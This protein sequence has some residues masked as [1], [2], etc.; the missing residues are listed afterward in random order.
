M[1]AQE[2]KGI[3]LVKF[4]QTSDFTT[5]SSLGIADEE[6][7]HE[8][9]IARM[10]ECEFSDEQM[11]NIKNNANVTYVERDIPV[12]AYEQKVPYGISQIQAHQVHEKGY[13]GSGVKL[14]ILDTGIDA[15][16]ED[17]NVADGFS[18]F[19]SG[20]DEDPYH[21]GSGHGTHVA[22]TAAAR[23]N[24]TGVVGVAPEAELYAVKVLDSNGSG[25]S[26]G[27]V[28]GIEW[29]IQ[30]EMSVINMSLG[31]SEPSRAIRDAL[32]AAYNE[33]DILVV[34]AA[35]NEGNEDGTGNTVGYP[36]QHESTIAVA[37]VDQNNERAPFSS[38]GPGVDIT[39]PG[40]S[41]FSATPDNN[42]ENLNGTSMASPHV[43]GAAAVL[44]AALPDASAAEIRERMV[45][46]AKNIGD[47]REWYGN[48]L[49]QLN[50]ALGQ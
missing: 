19:K 47:N 13:K 15:S 7:I 40:V 32:D 45:S 29:A 31:S 20:E 11:E 17:L 50:D 2:R 41:I 16:H 21:D 4:E 23:D 14:G 44:R 33:Y 27:V 9:N 48:G 39:A 30:N 22:G 34:A 35:G 25:S 6:V 26:A 42:Y 3:Y 43:A 28:R 1:S 49:L 24:D 36:A 18:V 46:T 38:T 37:A 5:Y 10:L 12:H 8:F